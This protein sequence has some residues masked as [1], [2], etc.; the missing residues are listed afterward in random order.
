MIAAPEDGDLHLEVLSRLMTMLMDETFRNELLSAKTADEFI[1]V[2]DRKES[3]KYPENPVPAAKKEGYRILAVTACPTGIAHTYMAAEALEKAGE[4][5]GIP[6]KAETNG[7]GGAK[8]VLTKEEIAAADGIIIAADK[9]VEMGRFDGKK[10]ISVKVSDGIKKPKELIERVMSD[11]AP[12]Y[13]HTGAKSSEKDTDTEG[14]GRN[15]QT[16]D[17][18]RVEYAPVCRCGRYIYCARLPD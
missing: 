14:F 7:S 1:S 18:R 4:E 11:S 6:L 16:P 17:E 2:I 15:I 3:E 5:M 8:N 13:H 9:S 12:V 10:L